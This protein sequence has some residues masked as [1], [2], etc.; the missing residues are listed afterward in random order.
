M[1]INRV[2]GGV[3]ASA[4]GLV[5]YVASKSGYAAGAVAI[6]AYALMD[7]V[8]WIS[9]PYERTVRELLYPDESSNERQLRPLLYSIA[10]GRP[11]NLCDT[12]MLVTSIADAEDRL[13]GLQFDVPHSDQ[14]SLSELHR[15]LRET[16]A[17][18]ECHADPK[19]PAESLRRLDVAASRE[20]GWR[21]VEE[22]VARRRAALPGAAR[23]NASLR[24]G[25]F[26]VYIPQD[27]HADGGAHTHSGGFF[28]DDDAPPPDTWVGHFEGRYV[29]A[30]VPT[31]L[32]AVVSTGV[33]VQLG[34]CIRWLDTTTV[35]VRPIV[36]FLQAADLKSAD[37]RPQPN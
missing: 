36:E 28:D 22:L 26:V 10:E 30:W 17:W 6:G 20:I 33:D 18:C 11:D 12:T 24:D 23:S 14:V 32:V 16:A 29:L 5:A 35:G 7:R 19:R 21:E 1:Q 2:I 8:G 25:R 34:D 3:I 13:H 27:S 31:S 15:R 37:R 9:S 4:C